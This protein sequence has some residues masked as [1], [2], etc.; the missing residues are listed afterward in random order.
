MK[1]GS[2]YQPHRTSQHR[3][4]RKGEP[5]QCRFRRGTATANCR[6]DIGCSPRKW[7]P[8]LHWFA[9]FILDAILFAPA[10]GATP[11]LPGTLNYVERS[12]GRGARSYY[13]HASR[14]PPQRFNT[15]RE[16]KGKQEPIRQGRISVRANV[17]L[18]L[19]FCVAA[20]CPQRLTSFYGKA[21]L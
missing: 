1:K 17:R 12:L 19:C 16:I 11:A 7:L 3:L 2:H 6:S 10:W 5:R 8:R 14:A 21:L 9:S 20:E 15:P 13:Y 18:S 4:Q